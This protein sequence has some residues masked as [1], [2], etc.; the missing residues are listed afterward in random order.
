[1]WVSRLYPTV[2][3]TTLD[4]QRHR[5]VSFLTAA[6]SDELATDV[7]VGAEHRLACR[8]LAWRVPQAVADT[9]RQRLR[10]EAKRKGRTESAERLA[11]CSWTVVVT[12]VEPEQLSGKEARAL[13]RARW[14]I[15]L[16]FKLW[17]SHGHVDETRGV[18]P[19]RVLCDVYAKRLA[20]IVQHWLCL[21]QCWGEPDRS[22]TKAA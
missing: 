8:L 13:L 5:V 9:R 14:Q 16:L 7:L 18:R 6:Q 10:E 19:Y 22:L 12:T 11:L 4:G 15:E 2:A 3:I 21:T 1:M 17:K 20:M